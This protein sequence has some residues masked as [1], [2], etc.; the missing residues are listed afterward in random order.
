MNGQLDIFVEEWM[1]RWVVGV[2]GWINGVIGCWMGG[3]MLVDNRMK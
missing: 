2:F 1:S 3:W